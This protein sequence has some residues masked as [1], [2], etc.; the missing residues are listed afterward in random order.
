M[1][2]EPPNELTRPPDDQDL[3]MLARELMKAPSWREKDMADRRF[4]ESLK[5]ATA[6]SENTG[7]Y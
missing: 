5:N 2:E 3:A 7:R 4:L 6:E 1:A